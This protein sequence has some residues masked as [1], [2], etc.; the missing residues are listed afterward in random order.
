MLNIEQERPAFEAAYRAKWPTICAVNHR[1]FELDE[2][3]QY[4]DYTVQV[5]LEMWLAAKR[6]S[7]ASA[8][9]VTLKDAPK[10]IYLVIEDAD[11]DL[12]FATFRDAELAA[13]A[14]VGLMWCHDRQGPSDIYYVRADLVAPPSTDAKDAELGRIAMR[15]VDRAGD[16][17]PGI[18]D[19]D[20]ICREFHKAMS[21]AIDQRG[22]A[23]Q[24]DITEGGKS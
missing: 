12:P 14:D 7:M 10:H 15:F 23:S 24:P 13:R 1:K 11:G 22:L 21:D 20:R 2:D 6:A 18:D 16:V 4:L 9:P 8:E 19:A 5:A 3:N 17:H